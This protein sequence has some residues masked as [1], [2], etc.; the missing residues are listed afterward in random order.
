MITGVMTTIIWSTTAIFSFGQSGAV[1]PFIGFTVHE[2]THV[3]EVPQFVD[4]TH[5]LAETR[6][7][8]I[9]EEGQVIYTDLLGEKQVVTLPFSIA[10]GHYRLMVEG[11]VWRKEQVLEVNNF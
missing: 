4:D 6:L 3:I 8:L 2:Q 5:K 10:K 7:Y 9:N 1:I 11:E